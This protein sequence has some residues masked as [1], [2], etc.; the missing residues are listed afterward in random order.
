MNAGKNARV[1]TSRT[2]MKHDMVIESQNTYNLP[3]VL[4]DL[5]HPFE[6]WLRRP[7]QG[8]WHMARMF[9]FAWELI[10]FNHRFFLLGKHV[11]WGVLNFIYIFAVKSILSTQAEKNCRASKIGNVG[12]FRGFSWRLWDDQ[13]FLVQRILAS[14]LPAPL[15]VQRGKRTSLK[16]DGGMF[17][18]QQPK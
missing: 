7:T 3:S 6:A 18:K 1:L 12:L 10:H 4:V 13:D 11:G 5:E 2:L 14:V 16:S 15:G 8:I 17:L 9:D